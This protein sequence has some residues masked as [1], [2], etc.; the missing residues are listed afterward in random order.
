MAVDGAEAGVGVEVS[1]GAPPS[2]AH[3]AGSSTA[4]DGGGAD[5]LLFWSP[6]WQP[7]G[8]EG[9]DYYLDVVPKV[10]AVDFH[11]SGEEESGSYAYDL[12]Q[13]IAT[14]ETYKVARD[15]AL[16][17]YAS[18]DGP[19][20]ERARA[21]AARAAL[22]SSARRAR[23]RRRRR[24]SGKGN[25]SGSGA[26]SKSSS[27]QGSSAEEEDV[28]GGGG[29]GGSGSGSGGRSSFVRGSGS[30]DGSGGSSSGSGSSSSY[31]SFGS[32]S[33]SSSDSSSGGSDG[34]Y[35]ADVGRARRGAGK[36]EEK[37]GAQE[38]EVDER[39]WSE[40]PSGVFASSSSSSSGS[41]SEAEPLD[42]DGVA[43]AGRRASSR[44]RSG[45][46]K[47]NSG[48]LKGNGVESTAT[49]AAAPAAAVATKIS[50]EAAPPPGCLAKGEDSATG[51]QKA[52]TMEVEDK[53]EEEGSEEDHGRGSPP[54]KGKEPERDAREADQRPLVRCIHPQQ[55][56]GTSG[57]L[58]SDGAALGNNATS[59]AGG[60]L[61]VSGSEEEEPES[62]TEGEGEDEGDDLDGLGA[63]KLLGLKAEFMPVA[64]GAWED[65][66]CLGDSSGGSD[67]ESR[68]S[69]GG[70]SA[71]GGISKSPVRT[72]A[73]VTAATAS[74]DD[75]EEDGGKDAKGKGREKASGPGVGA[76][77]ASPQKEKPGANGSTG[78][79]ETKK[80]GPT[81]KI[82]TSK[83]PRRKK[84]AA[85]AFPAPE[86]TP[87]IDPP[88]VLNPQVDGGGWESQVLLDDSQKLRKPKL[89]VYLDDPDMLFGALHTPRPSLKI[90]QTEAQQENSHILERTSRRQMATEKQKRLHFAAMKTGYTINTLGEG[91]ASR[92]ENNIRAV[93]VRPPHH[94]SPA[95]DKIL[96]APPKSWE[97]IRNLH[98][99]RMALNLLQPNQTSVIRLPRK[100][101]SHAGGAAGQGA[102]GLGA[103]LGETVS[104]PMHREKDLLPLDSR[105][106]F[107]V[108]EYVEE[109]PPLLG[110]TGMA[111]SIITFVR[112]SSRRPP[113][114]AA[115][116]AVA[117]EGAAGFGLRRELSPQE[118]SPFLGEIRPGSEQAS[119]CNGLFRAPIFKHYAPDSDFLLIRE[120]L[121]KKEKERSSQKQ[122]I[123]KDK[124]SKFFFSGD[125][126]GGGSGGGG[127]GGKSASGGAAGG[128]SKLT[129][130][131]NQYYVIRPIPVV[132]L[133]GQTEPQ[134]Q[135]LE[136]SKPSSKATHL[137]IVTFL[138]KRLF[139]TTKVAQAG[140][141]G[142]AFK[143]VLEEARFLSLPMAKDATKAR[144]K[145]MVREIAERRDSRDDGDGPVP[146][147]S[148]W[149]A[150]P[151]LNMQQVTAQAATLFRPED[152]CALESMVSAWAHLSDVGVDTLT[153]HDAVAK[154]LVKIKTRHDSLLAQVKEVRSA[155]TA[156]SKQKGALARAARAR[157]RPPPEHDGGLTRRLVCMEKL[158]E[159]LGAQLS[160]LKRVRAVA[161]YM[162]KELQM[163]PWT[164]TAN[165]LKRHGISASPA[166]SLLTL[167][168]MG[169]PSGCGEGFSFLTR[170]P[171]Q[172]KASASLTT[173]EK[174]VAERSVKKVTGTNGDLRRLT[175]LQLA[176]TCEAMGIPKDTVKTLRRWDRVHMIKELA[177]VAVAE[178]V[179]DGNIYAR[180]VRK[181][182]PNAT[183]DKDLYR[184]TCNEIWERQALAL[185]A[186]AEDV[187]DYGSESTSAGKVK[188]EDKGKGKPSP[189]KAGGGGGGGSGSGS[190]SGGGD[191]D[192]DAASPGSSKGGKEEEGKGDKDGG[193][194]DD[195][196]D[197]DDDDDGL[198]VDD[199]DLSDD[200]QDL[201]LSDM[202]ETLEDGDGDG[203]APAAK[204]LQDLTSSSQKNSEELD[205]ERQYRM[206]QQDLHGDRGEAVRWGTGEG[207]DSEPTGTTSLN[208]A[209]ARKAQTE[210]LLGQLGGRAE[211][212]AQ[213][214]RRITRTVGSDGNETIRISYSLRRQDL[215]RL[216]ARGGKKQTAI[217]KVGAGGGG[218]GVAGASPLSFFLPRP[219]ASAESKAA[220]YQERGAAAGQEDTVLKI[221]LKTGGA[222]TAAPKENKKK[223]RRSNA[224]VGARKPEENIYAIQRQNS[225]ST[226]ESRDSRPR[227]R[228]R[229]LLSGVIK[230]LEERA[231][232]VYFRAPVKKK[233]YPNYYT[234]I[235]KPMDLRTIQD[236]INSFDYTSCDGLLA[237][238]RQLVSNAEIFNGRDSGLAQNARDI[239]AD[240][241]VQL[242]DSDIVEVEA[243]LNEEHQA[244]RKKLKTGGSGGGGSGSKSVG[245]GSLKKKSS[246]QASKSRA[247]QGG[248]RPVSQGGMSIASQ[249][250]VS[251]LAASM[252]TPASS[253]SLAQ[254]DGLSSLQQP[255]SAV[256]A[257]TR[258][259]PKAP[260]LHG[261]GGASS[262]AVPSRPATKPL[263][264]AAAA[265]AVPA[266]PSGVGGGGGGG[267]AGDAGTSSDSSDGEEKGDRHF[268][269]QR[270]EKQ[271]RKMLF[272]VA[273][274]L[275][276]ASA[277]GASS[278]QRKYDGSTLSY[279]PKGRMFQVEYAMEATRRGRTVLGVCGE[280]CVVLVTRDPLPPSSC[281]AVGG[282]G[283]VWAVDTHVGIAASGLRSDIQYVVDCA[284][285][286][287]SEHRF[288]FGGPMPCQMLSR[289]LADLVHSCTTRGGK[290]PL[291]VDILVGGV[292]EHAGPSLHQVQATGAF[293]RYRA[294]ATGGGGAEATA[295]LASVGPIDRGS[296]VR[297]SGTGGGDD[298]AD[299]AGAETGRVGGYHDR[300]RR[301]L[302]PAH[303]VAL[304]RAISA[305]WEPPSGG[306]GGG[307][308]WHIGGSSGQGRG[309]GGD[310]GRRAGGEKE[311]TLGG[312]RASELSAAV[313]GMQQRDASCNAGGGLA[314]GCESHDDADG[315]ESDAEA[316]E[317]AWD[318]GVGCTREDFEEIL[319]ELEVEESA[320]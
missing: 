49:A 51:S 227:N 38:E 67:E 99:P 111:S 249:T 279:D 201:S 69:H 122:R 93:I 290:R 298:I 90:L 77:A 177:G 74:G 119:I 92:A 312:L 142:V 212:P 198:D 181:R 57:R 276:M 94:A 133:V 254:G 131:H 239:M 157:S 256:S 319:L 145:E 124:A 205:D 136:P 70:R 183:I 304:K 125:D 310:E 318:Q 8:L 25:G 148:L 188:G 311:K 219:Q 305:L 191:G 203:D 22:S 13:D 154:F 162:Y 108:V 75:D 80:P 283:G 316:G 296:G 10:D 21:R 78:A 222:S 6:Y 17:F 102:G 168:G 110:S 68:R 20:L 31:S 226:V 129:F 246:S 3:E 91:K 211:L 28:G 302:L 173:S 315:S 204:S 101:K 263:S 237:D 135:A 293:Q 192:G 265:A 251:A 252:S 36:D 113:M 58:G 41:D 180:F 282:E 178:N 56:Q 105:S 260:T 12:M 259:P 313:Y 253:A 60:E 196:D 140:N 262:A 126:G 210:E 23:H 215:V 158:S 303:R 27:R 197:D 243:A 306:G 71:G 272:K 233:F 2:S 130:R 176:S 284:R 149:A 221:R 275:C 128:T 209:E 52:D 220:A 160:E 45:R 269:R 59:S 33:D 139:D 267:M 235:K 175:M 114:G 87:W 163:V 73:V 207:V 118:D 7:T 317:R 147:E 234:V 300:R 248:A 84:E 217:S 138:A 299:D 184:A 208:V 186:T 218:G 66:V 11:D 134:M 159:V 225:R 295:R 115:A 35:G 5:G 82:V 46:D 229:A 42:R 190:G 26:T 156:L 171:E 193:D 14:D 238:M 194:N 206:L 169:D 116:E 15:Q 179:K 189:A 65:A 216:D 167:T 164:L 79:G 63:V 117:N 213:A 76:R 286:W 214:V 199:L 24:R 55:K 271:G 273:W 307:E 166:A 88:S 170:P 292:D 261:S 29:G 144:F 182:R 280:G 39:Y 255:T 230:K 266:R 107:V 294:V 223:R 106:T 54:T 34:E 247:A 241:Q 121:S 100:P 268:P 103:R 137:N 109:R 53:A 320:I 200:D 89:P 309:N 155:S 240:C 195:N 48:D 287:C 274:V 127:G 120:P 153:S 264:A 96:I 174:I 32:S 146:G 19:R 112:N 50:A 151:D 232:S 98:R 277:V 297:V 172:A 86:G 236:K 132:F 250:R 97:D 43:V 37:E 224:E 47:G 30:G 143:K 257:I 44:D 288:V 281:R 152:V 278:S 228:M 9:E 16:E 141:A 72:G 202:E 258:V 244:P 83:A 242:Q 4:H 95:E 285:T 62:S 187:Q 245:K 185:S 308:G 40:T 61:G 289:R 291:A 85:A 165:Y 314:G 301:S 81:K 270:G 123:K 1:S 18:G 161:Q 231:D 150:K 64:Q 104:M